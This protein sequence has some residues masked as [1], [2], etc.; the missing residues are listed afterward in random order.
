MNKKALF[1]KAEELVDSLTE[2]YFDEVIDN[3][4]CFNIKLFCETMTVLKEMFHPL[5]GKNEIPRDYLPYLLEMHR[6]ACYPCVDG[7]DDTSCDGVFVPLVD[8]KQIPPDMQAILSGNYRTMNNTIGD[9]R[10][11]AMHFIDCVCN[12]EGTVPNDNMIKRYYL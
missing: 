8:A 12:S 4:A 7:S 6:F 9:A 10:L 11:A 3:P 5:D 2:H 1:E